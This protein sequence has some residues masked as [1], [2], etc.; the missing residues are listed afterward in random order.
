MV[1]NLDLRK[2]TI[3]DFPCKAVYLHAILEKVRRFVYLNKLVMLSLPS[4]YCS[5]YRPVVLLPCSLLYTPASRL[6]TF[7]ENWFDVIYWEW[8]LSNKIFFWG[9]FGSRFSIWYVYVCNQTE[10]FCSK[11]NDIVIWIS[12]ACRWSVFFDK[13]PT[14]KNLM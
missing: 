9:S 4:P 1:R 5:S 13:L 8:I 7:H 11:R 14:I 2:A 12:I 3:F 10:Y 6:Y